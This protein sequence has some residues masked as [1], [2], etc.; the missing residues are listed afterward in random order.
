MILL[1]ELFTSLNETEKKMYELLE[2]HGSLPDTHEILTARYRI[3]RVRY[4]REILGKA[5]IEAYRPHTVELFKKDREGKEIEPLKE[6]MAAYR[7]PPMNIL[8]KEYLANTLD[9]VA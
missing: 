9:I 7:K 3:D 5:Y 6:N 2:D 4:L 1:T 8:L